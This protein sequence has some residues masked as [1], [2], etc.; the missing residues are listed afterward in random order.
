MSQNS[1]FLKCVEPGTP[2]EA[3]PLMLK[4]REP[5]RCHDQRRP[6]ASDG[7]GQLYT[8]VGSAEA[9]VLVH[10]DREPFSALYCGRGDLH[11]SKCPGWTPWGRW[12]EFGDEASYVVDPHGIILRLRSPKPHSTM[13]GRAVLCKVSR[14]RVSR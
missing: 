10:D 8:V 14:I 7:I 9:N 4:M 3:S 5:G 13:L 1:E 2:C 6:V 11:T 12:R